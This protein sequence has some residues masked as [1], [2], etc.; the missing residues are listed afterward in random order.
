M[1]KIIKREFTIQAGYETL[2]PVTLGYAWS[3]FMNTYAVWQGGSDSI[4]IVRKIELQAG[5]YY[6]TGTVDNYGSVNINGQYNINL[7]NYGSGISRTSVGNSTLVYHPGGAMTITISATNTGGPRGVAVTIS[8]EIKQYRIGPN[9]LTSSVGNLVWSTRTAGTAT[10]G[11]YA[12]TMPF[13]ANVSA[14]VWGAGG[15][16]GG[17]DAG[18]QGG[19]GSP[20]L[21]NEGF[22]EVE[23]GDVLEV[24]V[25]AGGRGG[26]SNS[27]GAPGGPGGF[28]RVL[29][30]G[31]DA[32]SLNGGSG[33]AAGPRP[34]S[35]GGGGGGVC[36]CVQVH[37]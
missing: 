19:L 25:G 5:N 29:I 11:R 7:Y 18:S 36:A 9:Q 15:G 24:F 13:R 17:M 28:S 4:T 22:F 6:V 3:S 34:Y 37:L 26:S 10:I 30:N 32:L 12:I 31:S 21:Y 27:G 35:G 20:G 1:S 16:G 2:S 8:E 14:Y 23:R 33:T